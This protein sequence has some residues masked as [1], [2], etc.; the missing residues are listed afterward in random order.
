MKLKLLSSLLCLGTLV[1]VFAQQPIVFNQQNE[2]VVDDNVQ[3]FK[4]DTTGHKINSQLNVTG[5]YWDYSPFTITANTAI[6]FAD[7]TSAHSQP[8]DFPTSNIFIQSGPIATFLKTS[9]TERVSTGVY[10]DDLVGGAPLSVKYNAPGQK[11]MEYPFSAGDVTTNTFSGGLTVSNMPV[12]FT[13]EGT[14]KHAGVGTVKI[15]N[16]IIS[17]VTRVTYKDQVITGST[18]FG[19]GQLNRTTVEYYR[20]GS[21][22]LPFLVEAEVELS[23]GGSVVGSSYMLEI[24]QAYQTYLATNEV[25]L[26]EMSI[27]PNPSTGALVIKGDF[28]TATIRVVD[29]QGK[30]V[31]I[32]EIHS[33]EQINVSTGAGIYFVS[34]ETE[35]GIQTQ[36]VI[37]K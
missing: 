17:N 30:E 35:K 34:V 28:E 31:M 3:M 14:V 15:G 37:V 9:A 7:V 18:I 6:M 12:T 36:K 13:G 10:Y 25:S 11:L 22:K 33:G 21:E 32:Q 8:A 23:L 29:V 19:V 2:P 27:A 24:D 16:G 26:F 5:N 1:P 4:I 20:V